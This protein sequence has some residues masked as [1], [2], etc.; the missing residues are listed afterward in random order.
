MP[1]TQHSACGKQNGG[2]CFFLHGKCFEKLRDVGDFIT[3]LSHTLQF[4]QQNSVLK[5]VCVGGGGGDK[6]YRLLYM[7]PL[8]KVGACPP[9]L[10]RHHYDTVREDEPNIKGSNRA[11]AYNRVNNAGHSAICIQQE[12]HT[13][14]RR[15]MQQ[16]LQLQQEPANR[17]T[18]VR[19]PTA[20][21]RAQPTYQ[22]QL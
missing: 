21:T 6:L 16:Q 5:S 7:V 18:I 1:C 3:Q 2:D 11:L 12:R 17:S 14:Q 13:E 15:Q 19:G 8:S 22:Q 9:P 20:T 4:I 10:S